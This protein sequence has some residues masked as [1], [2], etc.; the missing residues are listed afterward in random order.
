MLAIIGNSGRNN[1]VCANPTAENPDKKSFKGEDADTWDQWEVVDI[2]GEW[3]GLAPMVDPT[4]RLASM[5]W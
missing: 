1:F 3:F 5:E 4:L 2:E